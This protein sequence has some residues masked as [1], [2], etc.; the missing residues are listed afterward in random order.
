MNQTPTGTQPSSG[1]QPSPEAPGSPIFRSPFGEPLPQASASFLA[2]D[3]IQWHLHY[4]F[5]LALVALLRG[6]DGTL[7]AISIEIEHDKMPDDAMRNELRRAWRSRRA[8]I[9]HESEEK[10]AYLGRLRRLDLK[11]ERLARCNGEIDMMLADKRPKIRKW[12]GR[13]ETTMLQLLRTAQIEKA[14]ALFKSLGKIYQE[15][16]EDAAAE[17]QEKCPLLTDI[18][19]ICEHESPA[20]VED[21]DLEMSDRND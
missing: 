20:T 17:A 11:H 15:L 16:E 21:D 13:L 18:D 4:W 14:A 10:E 8:W 7:L 9:Q 1:A 19:S 12:V 2:T 3:P 5:G 6:E